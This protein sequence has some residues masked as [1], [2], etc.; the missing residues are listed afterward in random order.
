MSRMSLSPAIACR[1][2]A[3]TSDSW[4]TCMPQLMPPPP[5]LNEDSAPIVFYSPSHGLGL[6]SRWLSSLSVPFS[7]SSHLPTAGD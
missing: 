4:P 6:D 1:L 5:C 2:N 7:P 3:V